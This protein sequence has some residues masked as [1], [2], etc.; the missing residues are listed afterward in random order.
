MI[1]EEE[2]HNLPDTSKDGWK[3]SSPKPPV[4]VDFPWYNSARIEWYGRL[5]TDPPLV[6]PKGEKPLGLCER[7]DAT[8]D[9]A[10]HMT[11]NQLQH[12]DGCECM[13]E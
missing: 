4:V 7:E 10:D 1:Q 3:H 8:L 13:L 12:W 6:D 5:P 2:T 11:N 9:A